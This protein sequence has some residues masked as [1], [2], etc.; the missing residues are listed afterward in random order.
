MQAFR[1]R[2]KDCGYP[3]HYD[4]HL[5]CNHYPGHDDREMETMSISN[6]KMSGG[7]NRTDLKVNGDLLKHLP[8]Q[9]NQC[10]CSFGFYG[11]NMNFERRPEF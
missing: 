8:A 3:R 6:P 9:Q 2:Q 4:Q 7:I 1:R 11:S 10:S 5:Q